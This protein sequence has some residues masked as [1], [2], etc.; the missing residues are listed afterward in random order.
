MAAIRGSPGILVRGRIMEIVPPVT[1]ARFEK[2]E[3]GDLFLYTHDSGSSVALKTGPLLEGDPSGLVLLGPTF[4]HEM[5]E[6]FILPWQQTTVV[7]FGKSYSLIL[8]TDP[9]SWFLSGDKRKP[10]CLAVSGSEVYVCTNGG[11]S[12]VH[13]LQC[14]VELRT[15]KFIANCLPGIVAYT[16]HWKIVIPHTDASAHAIIK[17]SGGEKN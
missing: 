16:N 7:S 6:S 13:F 2:L 8:P 1:V 15:G 14:F 3:P 11:I 17:Y 12:P 5:K 10:V 9:T 4:P